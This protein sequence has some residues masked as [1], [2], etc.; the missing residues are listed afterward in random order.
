MLAMDGEATACRF[1]SSRIQLA[2][3]LYRITK[4]YGE[5]IEPKVL[6]NDEH[7]QCLTEQKTLTAAIKG[8]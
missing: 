5:E 3:V 7:L 4:Q 6:V 2:D 1:S 8:V